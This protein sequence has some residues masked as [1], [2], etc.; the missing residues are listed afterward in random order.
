MI[1][2]DQ[3]AELAA[4]SIKAASLTPLRTDHDRTKPKP[5]AAILLP[6]SR[7]LGGTRQDGAALEESKTQI[8]NDF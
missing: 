3:I 7:T 1:Y 8:N 6:N 2:I 5:A 4:E